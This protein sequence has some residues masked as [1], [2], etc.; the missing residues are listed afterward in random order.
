MKIEYGKTHSDGQYISLTI[1]H[2]DDVA[3]A[4]A[5]FAQIDAVAEATLR[6][7]LGFEP[8]GASAIAAI[9]KINDAAASLLDVPPVPIA[10]AIE[11]AK[12][13]TAPAA[14]LGVATEEETIAALRAF[15]KQRGAPQA[16]ALLSE[17]GVARVTELQPEQR[18]AFIARAA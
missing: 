17:F 18:T 3:E 10:Q 13:E 7:N 1:D 2:T 8:K 11:E 4:L 16:I 6:K 15:V 9:A 5:K 14:V 12:A